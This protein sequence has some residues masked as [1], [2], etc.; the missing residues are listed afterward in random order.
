MTLCRLS[1][2]LRTTHPPTHGNYS[3]EYWKPETD[4]GNAGECVK[5]PTQ[6][7]SILLRLSLFPMKP[8]WETKFCVKCYP[9]YTKLTGPFLFWMGSGY[10]LRFLGYCPNFS[11]GSNRS[12][13]CLVFG[14]SQSTPWTPSFHTRL[15]SHGTYNSIPLSS[16]VV[17][18]Q[19]GN[20]LEDKSDSAKA[21]ETK[22]T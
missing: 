11:T 14:G 4:I 18:S 10:F 1:C 6:N 20:R 13:V 2:N 9:L 12:L 7:T 17:Y 15:H 19:E 21:K 8:P 16:L 5:S 3:G 22:E